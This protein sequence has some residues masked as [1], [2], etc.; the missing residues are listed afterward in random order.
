MLRDEIQAT[1]NDLMRLCADCRDAYG[2]AAATAADAALTA[3]FEQLAE[4]RAD[5]ALALRA[6]DRRLGDLPHARD[7][8]RAT[9]TRLLSRLKARLAS[10]PDEISIELCEDADTRLADSMGEALERDDLPPEVRETV[11]RLQCEVT[12]ALGR[13]A[14]ARARL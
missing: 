8:D 6:L 10:D 14:A 12:A 4:Q 5:M 9:A 11:L 1:V 13:L 7:P 2:Q 3:L